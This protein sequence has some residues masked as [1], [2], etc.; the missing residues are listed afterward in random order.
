MPVWRSRHGA[1]ELLRQPLLILM[2]TSGLVL[3]TNRRTKG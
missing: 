3:L 1:Q 2:A